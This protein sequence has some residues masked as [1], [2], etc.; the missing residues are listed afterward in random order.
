MSEQEQKIV[1][2]SK[3]EKYTFRLWSNGRKE[4]LVCNV[5]MNHP[6]RREILLANKMLEAN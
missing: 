1:K 6:S 2:I 3:H 4:I 5:I